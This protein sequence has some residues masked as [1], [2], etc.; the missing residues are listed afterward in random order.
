MG[1]G[2][3][4]KAA[5][6]PM[7]D[8]D[9]K[10]ALAWRTGQPVLEYALSGYWTVA[11]AR[12]WKAAISAKVK[13]RSGTGAWYMVGDLSEL[14]TQPDDVNAIRDE[15]TQLTLA[16]GLAG[17]VMYGISVVGLIQL[18]RLLK[19]SGRAEQFAYTETAAEAERQLKTWMT[20]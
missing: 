13:E 1:I 10:F 12:A 4:F 20:P 16:N 19:A 11:D 7:V 15:V 3:T 14:K 6:G 5:G 17:C 8:D 2:S 9:H 18:R